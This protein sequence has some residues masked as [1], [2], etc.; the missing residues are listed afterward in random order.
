MPPRHS[1]GRVVAPACPRGLEYL[2]ASPHG[3]VVMWCPPIVLVAM[4]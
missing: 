1:C 4:W 3:R 2:L